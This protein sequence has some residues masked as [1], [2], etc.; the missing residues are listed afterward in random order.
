MGG[1]GID[2]LLGH[3]KEKRL[4]N[5][6]G[7]LRM[8]KKAAGFY[9]VKFSFVPPKNTKIMKKSSPNQGGKIYTDSPFMQSFCKGNR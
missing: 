6:N 7:V 9:P 1:N 8:L 2:F 5:F 3:I 4:G